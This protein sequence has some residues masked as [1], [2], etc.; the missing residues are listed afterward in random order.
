MQDHINKL[1]SY[2]WSF[3]KDKV[4][5]LINYAE[6]NLPRNIM[7]EKGNNNNNGRVAVITGSS[8]GI[9]HEQQLKQAAEEIS[10]FH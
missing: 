9:R 7:D 1:Y 3:F 10:N 6:L 8:K 5:G 2:N 4:K